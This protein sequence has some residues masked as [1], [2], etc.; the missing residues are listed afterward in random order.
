M[1]SRVVLQPDPSSP[2]PDK[3]TPET[4]KHIGTQVEALTSR[5]SSLKLHKR[6]IERQLRS[7]AAQ[8]HEQVGV[9][10]PRNIFL[11][12][13][14][15]G[16]GGVSDQL[17]QIARI[18]HE[19]GYWKPQGRV[20]NYHGQDVYQLGKSTQRLFD[21]YA[22]LDRRVEQVHARLGDIKQ[23]RQLAAETTPQSVFDSLAIAADMILVQGEVDAI[24]DLLESATR[25]GWFSWLF[26]HRSRKKIWDSKPLLRP[27]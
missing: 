22:K 23:R 7:I 26:V 15:R 17:E 3:Y 1:A 2:G 16:S 21:D 9:L 4:L 10:I 8:I 12:L 6:A 11:L 25:P 13:E 5:H 24:V 18:L 27:A 19:Q 20:Q 14:M